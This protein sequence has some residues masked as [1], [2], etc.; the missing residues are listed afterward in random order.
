M[1]LFAIIAGVGT[2]LLL[3]PTPCQ[4]YS[5]RLLNGYDL[6]E[7]AQLCNAPGHVG[8]DLVE[9]AAQDLERSDLFD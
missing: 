1:G 6:E 4:I 5:G 2:S 8:A 9:L 3:P 7:L